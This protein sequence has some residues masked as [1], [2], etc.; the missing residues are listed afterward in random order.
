MR[1]GSGG[2]K[3][4]TEIKLK[5]ANHQTKRR[6][7]DE[8]KK[9]SEGPKKDRIIQSIRTQLD[10]K[11]KKDAME[12]MSESGLKSRRVSMKELRSLSIR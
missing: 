9:K 11:K 1:A 12:R 3:E 6:P 8:H 5:G 10:R 7:G 4:T 2:E